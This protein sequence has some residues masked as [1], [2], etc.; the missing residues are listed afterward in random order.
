MALAA[1]D[2]EFQSRNPDMK[3][4]EKTLYIPSGTSTPVIFPFSKCE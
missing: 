1:K 2:V 3:L 4:Q